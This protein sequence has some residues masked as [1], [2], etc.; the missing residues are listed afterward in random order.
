MDNTKQE[1]NTLMTIAAGAELVKR[2]GNK[3]RQ[4]IKGQENAIQQVEDALFQAFALQD[5]SSA[6]AALPMSIAFKMTQE[7]SNL[8]LKKGGA[9]ELNL[10]EC[11]FKLVGLDTCIKVKT[12]YLDSEDEL[13]FLAYIKENNEA[14]Y[15]ESIAKLINEN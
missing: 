10:R 13:K 1:Y 3:L 6:Y 2:I 15:D 14:I 5:Y 8:I 7:Q 11:M 9:E 12:P 4:K